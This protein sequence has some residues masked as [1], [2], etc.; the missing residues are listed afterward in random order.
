MGTLAVSFTI[1]GLAAPCT[2]LAETTLLA[3]ACCPVEILA[4]MG[5]AGT[6]SASASGVA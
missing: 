3:C 2:C 6:C 5:L 1:G 4:D